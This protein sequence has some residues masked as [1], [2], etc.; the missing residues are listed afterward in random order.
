MADLSPQKHFVCQFK[1]CNNRCD[2]S[3]IPGACN[4]CHIPFYDSNAPCIPN[5]PLIPNIG[6][7]CKKC[8]R[9]YVNC[10]QKCGHAYCY[11]CSFKWMSSGNY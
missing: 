7:Q 4:G 6:N 8:G 3:H 10:C 9:F 2:G 1:D 5:A 11:D